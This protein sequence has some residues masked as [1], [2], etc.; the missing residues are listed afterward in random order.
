MFDFVTGVTR[1]SLRVAYAF[2]LVTDRYPPFSLRPRRRGGCQ[3]LPRRRHR[4]ERHAPRPSVALVVIGGLLAALSSWLNWGAKARELG[5][6]GPAYA[7]PAKFVILGAGSRQ[8]GDQPRGRR[9]GAR[10]ARRRG[11]VLALV[12]G[13]RAASRRGGDRDRLPVRVPGA[14]GRPRRATSGRVSATSSR[15]ARTSSSAACSP[16]SAR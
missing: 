7:I 11:G 10:A 5:A 6:A 16:S 14:Q 13:R 12:E 9:A 3:C 4:Q 2:L 15:S 8:P 1:W